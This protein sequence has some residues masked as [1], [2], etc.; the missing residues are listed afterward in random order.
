MNRKNKIEFGDFQ[1]PANL[2]RSVCNKLTSLGIVPTVI[3]E[4]TC[5][6]GAFIV[7][8]LNEFDTIKT[9]YGFEINNLYLDN[10]K[11]NLSKIKESEKVILHH[12]DFF[13]TDWGRLINS[14]DEPIFIIGN[15]PWITN[16]AQTAI[17][18]N[19]LPHK[20][21]F[22]KQNG[23]DALTGKAN[24][25]ISEW[26]LLT[27]LQLLNGRDA[28]IAMLVKTAVARKVLAYAEKHKLNIYEANLF[29]ID[30]KKDFGACV[31]AC[32]LV[33]RLSKNNK[34]SV[35]DYTIYNSIDEIQGNKISHRQGFVIK[36]IHDFEACSFLL[37][38][39]PQKW[40]SG[41]KHDASSVMELTRTPRGFINGFGDIVDIEMDYLFPLL[42]GSDIGSDKVWREKF[43][44][45]TQHFIGQETET[46]KRLLPKTWAYLESY[47]FILD[48]RASSIY[49]KNPRF[50][51]FGVG[52]Y[53]F[54]P[55]KI[56]ICSL[57]KSLKFRLIT[58]IENK[59]VM[60]DDTVYY[61]SFN[62]EKEAIDVFNLLMSEASLKLLS[63]LIFWDDKRPIKTSILNR[64][65]WSK[66]N[67][68][69]LLFT[70]H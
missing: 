39:S 20:S 45:V 58:S 3:I 2:A 32:L 12:A 19:N 41:I 15:F 9:I 55:W 49:K 59:P 57:Y 29:I 51:I 54:R 63:A 52:D 37:G 34:T 67:K 44:L 18:G 70:Q 8:A 50:A 22:L 61:L 38:Q 23:L 11:N 53:S 5:G 21:N 47:G 13:T 7:A 25:D 64:V 24:F 62:T 56:A 26:M 69:Q 66:I 68:T 35:Y 43:V 17:G 42:K 6:R 27:L 40:R 33:I 16:A 28:D 30:A 14:I 36:N 4:P 46:I 48:K 65:D 31:D 1:T 10:L 60:F